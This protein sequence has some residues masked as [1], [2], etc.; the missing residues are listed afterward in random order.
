M[1]ESSGLSRRPGRDQAP[2][3]LSLPWILI[4]GVQGRK[5][6]SGINSEVRKEAKLRAL[7]TFTSSM[8]SVWLGKSLLSYWLLLNLG[9]LSFSST[10]LTLTFAVAEW[11][12]GSASLAS[13]FSQVETT[14]T[15]KSL[16]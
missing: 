16:I 14:G 4:A 13:T 11:F 1:A 3:T 6:P 10:R 15:L 12:G 7:R 2:P 5:T 8:P 9:L